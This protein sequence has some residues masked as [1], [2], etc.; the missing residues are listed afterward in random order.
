[1]RASSA[2]RQTRTASA[3]A[4]ALPRR[5]PGA[6]L[7]ARRVPPAKACEAPTSAEPCGEEEETSKAPPQPC[8][9]SLETPPRRLSPKNPPG[10]EHSP[11]QGPRS[12]LRAKAEGVCDGLDRGEHSAILDQAKGVWSSSPIDLVLDIGEAAGAATEDRRTVGEHRWRN[13]H[14]SSPHPRPKSRDA[15]RSERKT[16]GLERE[17]GDLG[18]DISP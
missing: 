5:G 13:R 10:R 17:H 8:R 3:R 16:A 9:Q 6:R 14:S 2:T 1:M 11:C 15:E 12:G 4:P 7:G 18:E